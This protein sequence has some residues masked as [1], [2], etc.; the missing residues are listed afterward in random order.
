MPVFKSPFSSRTHAV[1]EYDTED[2]VLNNATTKER[3]TRG[4]S[5]A[6]TVL[7]QTNW[8]FNRYS[9]K[10]NRYVD[11]TLDTDFI[12]KGIDEHNARIFRTLVR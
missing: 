4:D 11:I 8:N 10:T 2:Y 1:P 12:K 9:T 6:S 7:A 3:I 5:N